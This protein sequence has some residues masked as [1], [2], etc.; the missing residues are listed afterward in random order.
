M[1]V[2]FWVIKRLIGFCCKYAILYYANYLLVLGV[3]FLKKK[4]RFTLAASISYY[5]RF[6]QGEMTVQTCLATGVLA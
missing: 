6:S 3:V 5:Q 2:F 4:F 1:E